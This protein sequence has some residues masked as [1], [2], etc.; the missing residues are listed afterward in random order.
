MSW[1]KQRYKLTNEQIHKI[2]S[3]FYFKLPRLTT[4]LVFQ[5]PHLKIKVGYFR[6]ERG[7]RIL[8]NLSSIE[9]CIRREYLN[10]LN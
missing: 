7:L 10:V 2:F 3:I 8:S 4:A 5:T 6:M 1:M 9:S